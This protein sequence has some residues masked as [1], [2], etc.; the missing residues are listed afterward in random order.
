MRNETK[1]GTRGAHRACRSGRRMI[2]LNAVTGL[3]LLAWT[4]WAQAQEVVFDN[5]NANEGHF[6]NHPAFSGSTNGIVGSPTST[7]DRVTTDSP[8]EGIGHQKLVLVKTVDAGAFRCRHLS[9]GGVIGNNVPFTTGAGT[10][11]WIGYYL[12]TTQTNLTASMW[13]EGPSN[14]F[15]TRKDIIADGQ[16]HLYEWNLDDDTKGADGWG[17]DANGILANA[18][19][20]ANGSHT[21]DSIIIRGTDI[22][23]NQSMTI[24]FDFLALNRNGSV[25]NMCDVGGN[26]TPSVGGIDGP[27]HEG[28]TTLNV[29]GVST[30]IGDNPTDA[31]SIYAN[32]VFL[33]SKTTGFARTGNETVDVT[34]LLAGKKG[35]RLTVTQTLGSPAVEGCKPD[36]TTGVMIGGGANP[37]VRVCFSIREDPALTGPIGAASSTGSGL[38]YWR[39]ATGRNSNVAVGSVELTPGLCWQTVSAVPADSVVRWN[40][41]GTVTDNDPN[42][43]EGNFGE[44]DA[45]WFSIGTDNDT[46]PYR[47]YIDELRNGSTLIQGWETGEVLFAQPSWSSTTDGGL[48]L[49]G[50]VGDLNSRVISSIPDRGTSSLRVSFQYNNASNQQGLRWLPN[51]QGGGVGRPQV[52][53]RLPISARFLV[54]PVGTTAPGA[55]PVFTQPLSPTTVTIPQGATAGPFTADA[56]NGFTYTWLV[57]GVVKASGV[58]LKSFTTDPLQLADNGAT[59]SVVVCDPANGSVHSGDAVVTVLSCNLPVVDIDGDTDVDMYDF[60]VFQSCLGLAASAPGCRCADTNGDNVVNSVDFGDPGNPLPPTFVGCASRDKVPSPCLP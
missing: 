40:A 48:L 47:I 42:V 51:G 54:L 31:L 24:F 13:I 9:G 39:P 21:I 50:P 60:Q 57:N 17:D 32:G 22:P 52:D 27:L 55:G 2:L 12:K 20:V 44:L 36:Q 56:G 11:G 7:A 41:T 14:N 10:D 38:I 3:A 43:L 6:T 19:T 29:R 26:L 16:W 25:A 34:G 53:L 5:F 37:K 49:D 59:V 58:D 23:A 1:T 28:L 33:T 8:R 35:Q 30:S 15:A 46:G 18:A 45:V 4:P